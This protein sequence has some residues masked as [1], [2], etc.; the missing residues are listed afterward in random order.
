MVHSH[1]VHAST[2]CRS[3]RLESNIKK[4]RGLCSLVVDR[5]QWLSLCRY[6]SLACLQCTPAIAFQVG[7]IEFPYTCRR[8]LQTPMGVTTLIGQSS[9]LKA[10]L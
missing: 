9:V 7:Y 1:S 3:N 2:L 8:S 4:T 10:I 5:S 6:G